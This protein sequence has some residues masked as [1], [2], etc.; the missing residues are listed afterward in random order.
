MEH[1][2]VEDKER[3]AAMGYPRE[4]EEKSLWIDRTGRIIE[5]PHLV[6]VP[7]A[8]LAGLKFLF[9]GW[10]LYLFAAIGIPRDIRKRAREAGP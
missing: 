3:L 9:S 8:I 2:T 1:G 7:L 4:D 6:F 10:H 5:G